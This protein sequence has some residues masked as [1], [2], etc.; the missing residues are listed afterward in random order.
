MTAAHEAAV[1]SISPRSISIGRFDKN[2][3]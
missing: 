2:T 3:K 1:F